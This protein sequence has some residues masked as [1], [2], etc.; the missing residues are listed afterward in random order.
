LGKE[1]GT[2]RD[3]WAAAGR[4]G[5]TRKQVLKKAW[6]ER[7]G[8]AAFKRKRSQGSQ[9]GSLIFK[10]H[11][12]GTEK[13]KKPP[14]FKSSLGPKKKHAKPEKGAQK[15]EGGPKL[16]NQKNETL[17]RETKGGQKTQKKKASNEVGGPPIKV[18]DET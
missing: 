2:E 16:S 17:P 1:N 12:W 10:A 8:W 3:P 7:G 4:G 5:K 14:P 18:S 15:P 13:K 11:A 6:S 9:K